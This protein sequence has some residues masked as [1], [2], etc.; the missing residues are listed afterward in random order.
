MGE[1]TEN[2]IEGTIGATIESLAATI[3]DRRSAPPD[4]SYT[5]QLLNGPE[6]K[7]L[8]KI[9]EE[10]SEVIMAAKDH[11]HDHLRYEAGDL[12]YHLLVVFERYDISLGEIA[13]ELDARMK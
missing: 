8:K 3:H 11:D 13:G 9:A 1:R 5:A 6:D 10:S 7:L 4:A 2:V 12:L